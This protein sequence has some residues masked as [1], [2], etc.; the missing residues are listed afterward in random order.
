[1]TKEGYCLTVDGEALDRMQ[2]VE[3]RVMSVPQKCIPHILRSVPYFTLD[4]AGGEQDWVSNGLHVWGFVPHFPW[5]WHAGI[6]AGKVP[7][8]YIP[9]VLGS[10]P[11]FALDTAREELGRVGN[12]HAPGM[13]RYSGYNVIYMT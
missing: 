1:M 13:Q 10:V 9:Y 12:R 6:R 7:Q 4:A 11:H 2:H 8:K 3:I 5:V